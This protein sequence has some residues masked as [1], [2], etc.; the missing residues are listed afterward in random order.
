MAWWTSRIVASYDETMILTSRS[1]SSSLPH[2]SNYTSLCR[3][4][5]TLSLSPSFLSSPFLIITLSIGLLFLPPHPSLSSPA[6]IVVIHSS[7]YTYMPTSVSHLPP[8]PSPPSLT[9][10]LLYYSTI[11]WNNLQYIWLCYLQLLT[12]NAKPGYR[13]QPMPT[14]TP[15]QTHQ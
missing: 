6:P 14:I 13:Q 15:F 3:Y 10:S 5:P 8:P 11:L 9:A 4:M 12:P 1:L 2:L 7:A